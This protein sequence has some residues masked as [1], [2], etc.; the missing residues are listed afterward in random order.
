MI[1]LR[2]LEKPISNNVSASSRINMSARPIASRTSG[3]L[4]RSRNRPGVATTISFRPLRQSRSCKLLDIPPTNNRTSICLCHVQT[5][6]ASLAIC[7]ASS[8]VGEMISVPTC[9]RDNCRSVWPCCARSGR[10][11]S[12]SGIILS[13]LSLLIRASMA[14]TRNA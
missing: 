7:V 5:L 3:S 14:G 11:P 13:S 8:R 4:S 12:S 10:R 9:V 6:R 2:S 1:K